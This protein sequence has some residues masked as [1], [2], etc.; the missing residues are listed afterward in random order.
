MST[1][2][3]ASL[4]ASATPTPTRPGDSFPASAPSTPSPTVSSATPSV[5]DAAASISLDDSM[6]LLTALAKLRWHS[7]P[8]DTALVRA[9]AVLPQH[10]RRRVPEL[11]TLLWVLASL[12]HDSPELVDE[13]QSAL[14][15]EK[16]QRPLAEELALLEA[17]QAR[18]PSAAGSGGA[19]GGSQPGATPTPAAT[20]QPEA[21]AASEA[22]TA[23]T[24][25]AVSPASPAPT[26]GEPVPAQTEETAA[27]ESENVAP[28]QAASRGSKAA[29][30]ALPESSGPAAEATQKGAAVG[31][32][33]ATVVDAFASSSSSSSAQV[34][35]ESD[36]LTGASAAAA[37]VTA[38][39]DDDAEPK[40][41]ERTA[42][43]SG[44][45]VSNP[46][47]GSS[48]LSRPIK[49]QQPADTTPDPATATPAPFDPAAATAAAAAAL[50][51]R[52][53]QQ[54]EGPMG[55]DML[56]SEP[57][58][59]VDVFKALW[60]CAKMNRHPGPHI[61]AAAER[62]WMS[63]TNPA[64]AA[65]A[66]P[67]PLHAITGL[68]WALAVFRHHNG[69]FAQRLAAQLAARLQEGR[70]GGGDG[71]GGVEA[72][73]GRQAL[74]VAACLLAAQADRAESPLNTSLAP[75]IRAR[76]VAAWRARL[77]QRMARPPNWYQADILSV[78]RKMGLTAAAN[79]ATPDGCAVV[80]VAVAL[81]PPRPTG[82]PGAAPGMATMM[83]GQPPRL[84]ALEL[85][86]RHN[87]AANS[88]RITGEAVI[89]YRLLQA[90]GYM[91][92]PVPCDEWDRIT[93]QDIWTK[94]VYL[95][96]KIERRT[97]VVSGGSVGPSAT[98]QIA[99]PAPPAAAVQAGE[100]VSARAGL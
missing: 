75:E 62:S 35:M 37:A 9:A 60:A 32:P 3:A 55:R 42:V 72:A 48:L 87:S 29:Q 16:P 6:R 33:H 81:M 24:V 79:V 45:G 73:F 25:P 96:A 65:A 69:S 93:F 70:E 22:L 14:L 17:G 92:V 56:P 51:Q 23:A 83:T 89:K 2:T 44:N 91:V 10:R 80:D 1:T 26:A 46:S 4:L 78:L 64:A 27:R 67:P 30:P 39:D 74:Q 54:L 84:L 71:S 43:D 95:Q 66:V 94:I 31:E 21:A 57:W 11:S 77:A 99:P 18:G 36:R 50:N 61:L 52:H 34:A 7:L 20:T 40:D 63:Y 97:A 86:G 19:G 82:L 100:L 12:Q 90:R 41:W 5:A 15:G 58:T 88:P 59:P 85:I 8:V 76:L 49:P 53:V 68:L 47:S 28:A 13:L 38:A 98:A